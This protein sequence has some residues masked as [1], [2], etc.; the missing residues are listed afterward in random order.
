MPDKRVK[1]HDQLQ[2]RCAA[3]ARS[4]LATRMLPHH[5]MVAIG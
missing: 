3:L 4:S 2:K 5:D 1:L